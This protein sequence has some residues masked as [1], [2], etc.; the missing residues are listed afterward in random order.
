MAHHSGGCSWK[1]LNYVDPPVKDTVTVY[2]FGWAVI[3]FVAD[4]PGVHMLH[5][6]LKTHQMMGMGGT[7]IERAS[8]IPPPPSGFPTCTM[9]HSHHHMDH[10]HRSLRSHLPT[11]QD[12][13]H[14][15]YYALA[16]SL[17]VAIV[18]VAL[19]YFFCRGFACCQR[20]T[21]GGLSKKEEEADK[22]KT[23]TLRGESKETLALPVVLNT[24]SAS[25]NTTNKL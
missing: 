10:E 18:L 16:I 1:K 3:R 8:E 14:L 11:D 25:R 4:N 13:E 20:E 9:D 12:R 17:A 7:I 19:A 24:T 21:D 22:S 2:P 6:H 23:N 15:S 5:C